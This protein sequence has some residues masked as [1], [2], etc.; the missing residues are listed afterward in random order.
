[1]DSKSGDSGGLNCNIALEALGCVLSGNHF[2]DLYPKDSILNIREVTVLHGP[3]VDPERFQALLV[4]NG[5]DCRL[6]HYL[7]LFIPV[8]IG[9]SVDAKA[10]R[11]IVLSRLRSHPFLRQVSI[12]IKLTLSCLI[13]SC[14]ILHFVE[15]V[16]FAPCG[17]D[18]SR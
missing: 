12:A 13:V 16:R 1:M 17:M 15:P 4:A 6:K 10:V 7:L 2:R 3:R 18:R 9:S 11:P 5:D 14:M 8:F